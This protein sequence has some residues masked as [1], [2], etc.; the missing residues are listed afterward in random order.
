MKHLRN[1]DS[2]G[3][4]FI[5]NK[6]Y[7]HSQETAIDQ[8]KLERSTPMKTEQGWNGLHSVS[9]AEDIKFVSETSMK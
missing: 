4:T 1:T 3:P 6:R 7:T 9:A 8:E 2:S 5:K